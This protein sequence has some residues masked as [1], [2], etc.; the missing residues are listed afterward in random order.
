MKKW[1][2]LLILCLNVRL[3]AQQRPQYSQYLLNS[4]LLNPALSGIENYTDVKL[5]YRQ[6]WA[7][8][9][10]APKTAFVSAHW[11]LGDE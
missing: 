6:Q 5:G 9:Q 11:A 2:L 3:Y 10:D 7:G 4:Y 8:L 1:L